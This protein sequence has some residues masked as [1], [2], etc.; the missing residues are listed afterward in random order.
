MGERFA[1]ARA[2][3]PAKAAEG[4]A[5]RRLLQARLWGLLR[6]GAVLVYPTSPLP[7]PLLTAS[8]ADTKLTTKPMARN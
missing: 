2:M 1:A 4:R 3:D 8:Q 7:A 5:F 6:G